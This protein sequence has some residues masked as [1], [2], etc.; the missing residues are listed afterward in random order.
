M[1]P[2]P[3]DLRAG[4]EV[5]TVN[6]DWSLLPDP[7][8]CGWIGELAEPEFARLADRFVPF[9]FVGPKMEKPGPP[10]W[11]FAK[12]VNGGQH[13]PRQIQAVGDCFIAGTL[14]TMADG[15]LKPIEQVVI[16]DMVMSHNNE[17]R[18]V[19]DVI[20]KPYR[21]DLVTM[22]AKGSPQGVTATPDHRFLSYLDRHFGQNRKGF[23][24][25]TT[26]RTDWV[27]IGVL[28]PESS[29]LIPRGSSPDRCFTEVLDLSKIVVGIQPTLFGQAS[30]STGCRPCARQIPVD[31]RFCWLVGIYL[32][33]GSI[34]SSHS[35]NPC[36]VS[37]ALHRRETDLAAQ[38]MRI[39]HQL[40]GIPAK[41]VRLPSKP[42]VLQVYCNNVALASFFK[43][44][45]PGN[46]YSKEVPS[47]IFRANRAERLACLRGWLDGDGHFRIAD[48]VKGKGIDFMEFQVSWH[49]KGLTE[50]EYNKAIAQV[51]ADRLLLESEEC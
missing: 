48:T 12:R 5:S 6:H 14:V 13:L 35:G 1:E 39:I 47:C 44:I 15:S 7:A 2:D 33:E 41:M 20:A 24:T 22:Q 23:K 40:F 31:E 45:V 18:Q 50:D 28:S 4:E 37:F 11:E 51:D 10:I 30:L 21:G 9:R 16:G 8:L 46:V 43:E 32:A 27:A 19:L 3:V 49:S 36:R 26:N 25:E 38:I 42:N 34:T 17:P 29:V